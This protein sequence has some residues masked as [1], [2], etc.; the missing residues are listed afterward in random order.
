MLK[1]FD[2]LETKRKDT[3]LGIPR[4]EGEALYTFIKEHNIK[5]VVETGIAWGFT[6]HYILAALPENGLLISLEL[7]ETIYTGIVVPKEWQTPWIKYFGP[8]TENLK[9]VFIEHPDIDLF[10]HDSC[11]N[12]DTQMF[13]Y[14][15][16]LAFV[17]YLGSHDI[18]LQGPPY[19]WNSFIIQTRAPVLLK[20]GQLGIARIKGV[21]TK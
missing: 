6:S 1:I 7:N 11:H 16:A 14:K 20:K 2:E 9:E 4:E 10:F 13:E 3:R 21:E 19:A 12:F 5:R 8:S 18:K 15:T 17:K